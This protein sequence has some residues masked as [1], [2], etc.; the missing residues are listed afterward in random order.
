MDELEFYKKAGEIAHSVREYAK[1]LVVKGAKI[2]DICDKIE[3]KIISL[4]AKPAFPVQISCNEIAAHYCPEKD[5]ETILNDEVVSVD[6]GVS[7]NGFI[8]DCAFTVDLSNKN[9][10]LVK[11]AEEALKAAKDCL[12]IGIEIRKI[13]SVIEDTIKS[14]GFNPIRNLGGHGLAK[15]KIHTFPTIPNYDNKDKTK[16]KEG[17]FIAIEPFASDGVGFVEEK[18]KAN[19]FSLTEVKPVRLSFV[20]QI[21]KEIEKFNGMP[22]TKRWLNFPEAQIEFAFKQFKQLG[23]LR[24]YPPLVEKTKGLVSQAEDS[25]YIGENIEVLT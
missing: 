5:E 20:R 13:G 25:F 12:K 21:L 10:E 19:V 9:K 11:A 16:L 15:F 14:Y 1:T 4:G 6:I 2:V 7:V 18:G 8:G 3:E 23:I 17:M 24:E 22:F